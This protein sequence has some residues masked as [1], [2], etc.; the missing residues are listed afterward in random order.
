MKRKGLPV[1][2]LESRLLGRAAPSLAA[3]PTELA[4]TFKRKVPNINFHEYF[5]ATVDLSARGSVVR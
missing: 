4:G 5:A 3:I 1:T 2:G